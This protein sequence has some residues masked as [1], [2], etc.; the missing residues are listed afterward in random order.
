MART[1]VAAGFNNAKGGDPVSIYQGFASAYGDVAR[2]A[3]QPL[4]ADGDVG[5]TT[6]MTT[7][8]ARTTATG[9]SPRA[10]GK[11]TTGKRGKTT[12]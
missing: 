4:Q 9:T 7:A 6:R 1:R 11:G 12:A 5:F 10:F 2:A 8:T 3:G